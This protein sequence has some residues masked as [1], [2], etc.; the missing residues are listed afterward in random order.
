MN[1]NRLFNSLILIASVLLTFAAQANEA[2]L[3]ITNDKSYS[4]IQHSGDLVTISGIQDS[5]SEKIPRPCPPFC[6]NPLSLDARVKAVAEQEVIKFMEAARSGDDSVLIDVRSPAWYKRGTIPG[7][8]NIP[9]TVFEKDSSDI[10]LSEVL[11]ILGA[12]ERK[13]VNPVLHMVEGFGL[14]D[15]DQKTKRWDFTGA[16]DLLLWCSGSWCSQS[17]RAIRGLISVGYP[18]EKISYYRGGF[19]IWQSLG[20]I[21][22]VPK[23]TSVAS[24]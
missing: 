8:M 6:T 2:T 1:V 7:S 10:E 13:H 18:A 12:V 3:N 14:L 9:F 17:P 4:A 20:L 22:M 11:E 16:K 23:D 19:Q 5:K 24:K 21:T 15:G